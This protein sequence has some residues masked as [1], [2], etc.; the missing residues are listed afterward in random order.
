VKKPVRALLAAVNVTMLVFVAG[1]V[2]NEAVTP[3]PIPVADRVTLPLNPFVLFTV[4]V[5][6]P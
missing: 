6:V 5:L 4:T 1:F 2:P 3:D